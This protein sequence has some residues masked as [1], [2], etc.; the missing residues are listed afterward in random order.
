MKALNVKN[1]RKAK[2][3]GFTII[4]LVVVILLLGILT[5]TALPRFMDVTDE[6]H[7]AVVDAVRG[8]LLTSAAL[9]RAQFVGKGEPLGAA[10]ADFGDD[11]LFPDND[12][13]GYPADATDGEINDEDDCLAVYNGLLQTGR[14]VA[15]SA[16][17]NATPATLEANIEAVSG[18]ADFVITAVDAADPTT[19]CVMYYVGQFKSG[20]TTASQNIPN[21]TYT[22]STGAVDYGTPLTLD[23]AD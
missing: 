17:F 23:Q 3:Q 21:L 12:G 11:T 20:N 5:A 9:F 7:D 6:A 1:M 15:A 22:L 8:G 16:A 19:G 2:Q 13:T 14:P 4:E 10:L 18:A